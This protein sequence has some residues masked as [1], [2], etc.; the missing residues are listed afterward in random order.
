MNKLSS[1]ELKDKYEFVYSIKDIQ[2]DKDGYINEYSLY[3]EVPF[4][5]WQY[6]KEPSLA[7]KE[8]VVGKYI[9]D[10]FVSLEVYKKDFLKLRMEREDPLCY[11]F[12]QYI[13]DCKSAL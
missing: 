9:D 5:V 10:N 12:F 11:N 3:K 7:R 13:V 4:E 8:S 1:E 2:T 6:I